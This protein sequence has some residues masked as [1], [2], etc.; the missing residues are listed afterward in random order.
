MSEPTVWWVLCGI[1]VAAE[2]VT[3]TFYLLMLGVGLAAGALASHSGLGTPAQLLVASV[4]G[5]GA[6]LVWSLVRGR[7]PREL[8][9][10]SNRDVNLDIGETVQVDSWN[11]D[12]TA[13]IR[14]RGALWTAVPAA[15]Q[16]H[17]S[18]PHRV[19]EVIGSRLVVEKI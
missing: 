15:G 5:G 7:R 11:A 18:G 14:Y 10:G 9:A 19:R 2:L 17:V 1:A 13:S 12:G 6:V 4:V 3:G 8:P 16:M